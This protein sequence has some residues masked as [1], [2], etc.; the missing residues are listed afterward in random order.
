LLRARTTY[1]FRT[2]STTVL[3]LVVDAAALATTAALSGVTVI[4]EWSKHSHVMLEEIPPKT[5]VPICSPGLGKT[6]LTTVSMV[7]EKVELEM[8]E[9]MRMLPAVRPPKMT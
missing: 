6:G 3:V 7:R 2:N 4:I 5:T 1:L 8:D 9:I